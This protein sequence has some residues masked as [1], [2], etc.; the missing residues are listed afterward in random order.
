[1]EGETEEEAA[2]LLPTI[3][4]LDTVHCACACIAECRLVLPGGILPSYRGTN[5]LLRL[6]GRF[7]PWRSWGSE[8]RAV[9]GVHA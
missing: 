7:L 5:L 1:M 6:V 3:P 4:S 9:C 8:L 2:H